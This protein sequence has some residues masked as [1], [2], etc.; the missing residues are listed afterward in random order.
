MNLY[1]SAQ[2]QAVWERVH[3]AM[4]QPSGPERLTAFLSDCAALERSYRAMAN[5][6]GKKAAV[7]RNM[8]AE[9]ARH[10]RQLSALYFLQNGEKPRVF[11]GASEGRRS[12]G[13][14]LRS[15]YQAEQHM[16]RHWQQGAAL[17]P[18]QTALFVRLAEDTQRHLQQ[19]RQL[20]S[21]IM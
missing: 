3:G 2:V 21:D 14:A 4:Q 13:A 1:D 16:L 18:D 5:H 19:L 9:E 7:L 20:T 12:Y 15:C 11:P 10:R 17:W 6:A 8:A